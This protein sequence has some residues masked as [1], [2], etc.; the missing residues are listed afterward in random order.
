MFVWLSRWC[1]KYCRFQ[2]I[3]SLFDIP[4]P[5]WAVATFQYLTALT[6]AN[7]AINPVLYAF[8]SENFRNKFAETFRCAA[9]NPVDALAIGPRAGAARSIRGLGSAASVVRRLAM[10]GGV[11]SGG[12]R[13][14]GGGSGG[15]AARS[16]LNNDSDRWTA[17]NHRERMYPSYFNMF[18]FV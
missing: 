2:V 12:S 8:L 7:S 6:Y 4:M 15:D 10:F 13:G 1:N 17:G 5:Q 18:V 14:S 3:A 11:L 16:G 9:S